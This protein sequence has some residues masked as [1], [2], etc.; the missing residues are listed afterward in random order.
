MKDFGQ[1]GFANKTATLVA[2]L[3][4]NDRKSE[5]ERISAK[6]LKEWN[7]AEFKKQLKKGDAW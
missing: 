6:A 3:V 7:S 5:A 2:L 1:K 4:L